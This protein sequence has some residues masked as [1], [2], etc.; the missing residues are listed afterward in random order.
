MRLSTLVYGNLTR[1]GSRTLLTLLALATAIACVVALLGI[2]KGFSQ[3]FAEVY[4]AHQ[5]DIVVSRQGAADRLSSAVDERVLERLKALPSIAKAEGVLLET[6]SFEDKGVY[7]VP[8]MGIPPGSWLLQ[9]YQIRSGRS[10]TDSE[11]PSLLLGVHLAERLQVEPGA[12]VRLFDEDYLVDGVFESLSV[13]ENGSMVLPLRRLQALTDRAQQV[14]YINVVLQPESR[15]EGATKAIQD[16]QSLD[17]KLLALQTEEFV[18]T[19]TRMQIASAMAWMTSAIALII[20]AIG[21]LNTMMMSVMERTKEI[22]VLR[23]IGWSK[24]RIVGMILLESAMLASLASILGCFLA[25]ILLKGLGQS[26]IAKGILSPSIDYSVLLQGCWIGLG[27]GILGA[28]LPAWRA[29]RLLPT[30][31]FRDSLS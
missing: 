25:V 6:L 10:F 29:A 27:I 22:G 13:W 4:S 7:G 9:D 31:A 1:R 20:G 28:L 11:Q 24:F 30:V 17:P 21:T 12:K 19:D 3:S 16:I 18:K 8:T 23:A 5:V 14:T 15:S 26:S 2:A